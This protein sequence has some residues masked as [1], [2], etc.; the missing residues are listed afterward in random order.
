MFKKRIRAWGIDKKLK[1]DDVLEAMSLK[2]ERDEAGLPTEIVIRGRVVSFERIWRYIERK[3]DL[4][5]RKRDGTSLTRKRSGNVICRTPSPG[6][7]TSMFIRSPPQFCRLEVALNG[8]RTTVKLCVSGA[9]PYTRRPPSPLGS[10]G[11][12]MHR[13]LDEYTWL[14]TALDIGRPASVIFEIL[15]V[16]LDQLVAVLKTGSPEFIFHLLEICMFRFDGQYAQLDRVLYRHI[17][18]LLTA[19]H[20]RSHPMTVSWGQIVDPRPG[21]Q[22]RECF[23]GRITELLRDELAAHDED[24]AGFAMNNVLRL[25]FHEGHTLDSLERLYY[26]WAAS[27]SKSNSS[28][29]S[30][31]SSSSDDEGSSGSSNG[32]GGGGGGGGDGWWRD[33]GSGYWPARIRN[34]SL[35]MRCQAALAAGRA[36][37]A[38]RALDEADAQE[39]F[40]RLVA[41]SSPEIRATLAK[42]RGQVAW[43]LGDVAAAERH[44]R[45]AAETARPLRT[46]SDIE[47]DAL[48]T[49]HDVYREQAAAVG[50][51]GAVADGQ[52]DEDEDVDSCLAR[53]T[54]ELLTL[55]HRL[56]LADGQLVR[57]HMTS[58]CRDAATAMGKDRGKDS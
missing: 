50:E 12:R 19:T 39:P 2:D 18:E 15:N 10:D 47:I 53:V 8:V 58:P 26:G 55:Q 20:G 13:L 56:G 17:E 44:L 41:P 27:H 43:R 30:S 28:S 11:P 51:A 6:S 37:E 33:D 38:A 14:Q 3:P 52:E 46:R 22:D 23:L 4:R 34:S 35:I 54:G 57:M 9:D 36:A 32:G 21:G 7:P 48:Q 24:M 40:R 45:A 16:K 1:E 42:L 29:S 49:L 25:R 5:S 31:S